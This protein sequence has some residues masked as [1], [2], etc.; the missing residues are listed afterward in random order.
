MLM[1][2]SALAGTYTLGLPGD[3]GNPAWAFDAGSPRNLTLHCAVSHGS[4]WSSGWPKR[5]P[6]GSYTVVAAQ[7]DDAGHTTHTSPRTFKLIK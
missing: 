1:P 3:F 4:S 7:H 6:R 5:L 2:G